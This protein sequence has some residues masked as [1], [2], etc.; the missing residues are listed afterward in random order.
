MSRSKPNPKKRRARRKFTPEFKA[1]VVRLCRAGGESIADVARRLDL[2]ETAVRAWVEQAEV[3][4]VGGTADAL[5]T[6]EREELVRLRRELKPVTEERD[7]LKKA[8]AFFAK[9]SS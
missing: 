2:T 8:T 1:D 7:I 5:T 3:D 6:K 9:E 4:E